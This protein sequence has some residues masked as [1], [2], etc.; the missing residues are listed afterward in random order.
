MTLTNATTDAT[1]LVVDDDAATRR[2]VARLVRSVGVGV[3]TFAS[4]VAFLRN[5]LPAGP[6]CV[7]LDMC[8]EGMTGL[9]VQNALRRN[10]RHVPVVFLSGQSTIST[11]VAG[12]RDGAED[13]LEKPFRPGELIEVLNRALDRDRA[14]NAERAIRAEF[15]RRFDSLTPREQE[16]MALVVT[17]LLNKQS[18]AELGIT[19]KTIKVHRARVM[20]K[21]HVESLAELVMI[22]ERLGLT[23]NHAPEVEQK[24][25]A[26]NTHTAA[27][28]AL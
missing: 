27:G 4:P 5:E 18:A 20:E 28:W 15:Q 14:G 3:K 19:E 25:P 26:A 21:M 11:A 8:M 22:A 23:A 17:G 7:L 16:V 24:L 2:S 10:D 13:F 9:E 12:V 6:A 1:V